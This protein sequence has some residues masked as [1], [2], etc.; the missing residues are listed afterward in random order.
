[1]QASYHYLT[2]HIIGYAFSY[3]LVIYLY[4]DTATHPLRHSRQVSAAS[5]SIIKTV[6]DQIIGR[7]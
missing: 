4:L 2:T 5:V 7:S 3:S 1:M 6:K